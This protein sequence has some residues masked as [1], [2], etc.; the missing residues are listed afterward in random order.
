[1]R[2]SGRFSYILFSF[3]SAPRQTVLMVVVKSVLSVCPA[4]SALI[5]ASFVDEILALGKWKTIL[6]W[7]CLMLGM[8]GFM[9][10]GET[11]VSYMERGIRIRNE[12][13]LRNLIF[14]KTERLSFREVEKEEWLALRKRIMRDVENRAS[15]GLM[16]QI[17]L[18]AYGVNIISVVAVISFHVWWIGFVTLLVVG[19]LFWVSKFLGQQNY[20]AFEEAEEYRRRADYLHG[21][22]TDREYVQEKT[23]F[24]YK[25]FVQNRW[26]QIFE[27]ARRIEYWAQV[28]TFLQAGGVNLVT[29]FLTLGICAI[30]LFPLTGGNISAGTYMALVS[31]AF[32]LTEGLAWGLSGAMQDREE[33]RLYGADLEKFLQWKETETEQK[34]GQ[35]VP[36]INTL[37]FQNVSFRYP[38]G[39]TDVLHR[40]S[41]RMECGKRYV[42]LGTN[43][44]GKSTLVKL[45][46]GLYT[47]YDG[48][49]LINGTELRSYPIEELRRHMAFAFQDFSHYQVSVK[50]FVSFSEEMGKHREKLEDVL[51][52]V[53]LDSKIE[54]LSLGVDTPL[55]K[56]HEEGVELS[57]GEWQRLM[58]ARNMLKKAD[59]L[60]LD[61]PAASLDPIAE[62]NLYREYETYLG[63]RNGISLMISHRLGCLSG[64][65]E[66]FV[67]DEG[68]LKEQGTKEQLLQAGGLLSKMYE[69]QEEWYCEKK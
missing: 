11:V 30:L 8:V 14:Q 50:E 42:L 35:P 27:K 57:G 18:S 56:I 36:T 10:V 2:K 23:I 19:I 32:S 49:I 4:L 54:S 48:K 46:A 58:I 47:N 68:M 65:D 25:E 6:F 62:R 7:L 33:Y 45:L 40:V 69:E 37:E 61:E 51:K 5:L 53:G 13:K 9:K 17:G 26:H 43:G 12:A 28:K 31:A 67:L 24:T 34:E 16:N 39:K 20:E 38:Q 52:T 1:M 15:D 63:E 3:G 59:V 29:S 55:G 41:F 22:L 21:I 66:I 44:A 64:A 60:V